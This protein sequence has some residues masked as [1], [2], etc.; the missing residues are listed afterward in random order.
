MMRIMRSNN[1][2]WRHYSRI[3]A[4]SLMLLRAQKIRLGY[5]AHARRTG[6]LFGEPLIGVCPALQPNLFCFL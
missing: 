4:A 6:L 5:T 2:E 3:I 1:E